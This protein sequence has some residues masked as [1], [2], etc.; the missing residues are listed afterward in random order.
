[1]VLEDGTRRGRRDGIRRRH[2]AV[3]YGAHTPS[4]YLEITVPK[5]PLSM[6]LRRRCNDQLS[7][8]EGL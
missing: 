7:R 1:M 6:G 2:A 8:L 3:G 4:L 5:Q